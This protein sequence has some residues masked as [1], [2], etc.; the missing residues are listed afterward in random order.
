MILGVPRFVI[1]AYNQ[2][3]ILLL[4]LC[5]QLHSFESHYEIDVNSYSELKLELN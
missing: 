4:I 1:L 2:K 3:K 5:A